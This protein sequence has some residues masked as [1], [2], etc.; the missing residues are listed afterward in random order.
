MKDTIL[1]TVESRSSD[2]DVHNGPITIENHIGGVMV[3]VL[4]SSA[5]DRVFESRSN[6]KL[7]NWY[8][9]LLW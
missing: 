1:F 3:S 7:S 8:L 6:Q 4:A 5:V 9:L 2:R